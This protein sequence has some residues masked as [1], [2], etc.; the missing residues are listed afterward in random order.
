MPTTNIGPCECCGAVHET[1][2]DCLLAVESIDLDVAGFVNTSGN[3]APFPDCDCLP[4]AFNNSYHL[5]RVSPFA[6]DYEILLGTEGDYGDPGPKVLDAV[7]GSHVE[8][9][10]WKITVNL[11]CITCDIT[12]T[13]VNAAVTTWLHSFADGTHTGS[14]CALCHPLG[15]DVIEIPSNISEL[16]E[17]VCNSSGTLFRNDFVTT[18]CSDTTFPYSSSGGAVSVEITLNF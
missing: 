16:W 1:C 3:N 10:C 18:D 13:C 9:F 11:A 15:N 4:A 2:E 5:D 8:C 17:D 14:L 6:D 12:E 7:S